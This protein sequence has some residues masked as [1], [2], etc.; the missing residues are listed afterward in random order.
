MSLTYI[1]MLSLAFLVGF[2][3]PAIQ[4]LRGFYWA[5]RE[6]REAEIEEAY[7]RKEKT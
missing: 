2:V 4:L 3:W 1:I 5:L 7:G 6:E